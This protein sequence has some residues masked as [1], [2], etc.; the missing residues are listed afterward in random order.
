[1]RKNTKDRK[2]N[3]KPLVN[4]MLSIILLLLRCLKYQHMDNS[5]VAIMEFFLHK[6]ISYMF[7]FLMFG[8]FFQKLSNKTFRQF[9]SLSNGQCVYFKVILRSR[10]FLYKP[11]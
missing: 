8:F 10:G 9:E 1:M 5:N 6:K 4:V 11:R 3:M 2:P 7:D